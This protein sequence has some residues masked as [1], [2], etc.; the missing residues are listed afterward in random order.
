[1]ELKNNE[2]IEVGVG[3]EQSAPEQYKGN[4][5]VSFE[6]VPA[7]NL[8]SIKLDKETTWF[9]RVAEST[10]RRFFTLE[11][12]W[13]ITLGGIEYQTE[14]N[15][16]VTVSR[17]SS[18]GLIVYDG[19]SIPMPWLVS[20]ITIGILRPL[21]AMLIASLVHDYAFKFGYLMVRKEGEDVAKRI[22]IPR[23]HADRLFHDILQTV[24][25]TFPV[26]WIAWFAVRLGWLFGVEYA[27]Q[28]YGGKTPWLVIGVFTVFLG[29]FIFALF[30]NFSKVVDRF[31]DSLGIA[32]IVYFLIYS[33]T[34]LAVKYRSRRN[35][36]KT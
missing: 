4:I 6:D 2:E 36:K 7:V 12:D 22:D 3:V 19:A 24:N 28:K 15:G 26:E 8:V 9:M 32:A 31:T 21:G 5:E 23:H 33:A 29:G 14:L 17:E 18:K 27:N 34:V 13:Q 1:M 25:Q 10:R 35:K 16:E 20:F 30:G 11:K